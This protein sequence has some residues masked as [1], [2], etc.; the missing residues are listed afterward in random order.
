MSADRDD[1][2]FADCAITADADFIVTSDSHFRVLNGS[3]Y[4]PQPITPEAFIDRYLSEACWRTTQPATEH[5]TY[6][7]QAL[8]TCLSSI[9]EI[10]ALFAAFT[11]YPIQLLS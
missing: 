10:E 9:E 2:K 1:D 6:L 7:A 3:G 5:R 11:F 4:R 8:D